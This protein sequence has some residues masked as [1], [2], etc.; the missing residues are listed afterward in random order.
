[1]LTEQDKEDMLKCMMDTVG[2]KA[3]SEFMWFNRRLPYDDRNVAIDLDGEPRFKEHPVT[4]CDTCDA[5]IRVFIPTVDPEEGPMYILQKYVVHGV[6]REGNL[7]RAKLG[8]C[9]YFHT[10]REN[11]VKRY[12]Y[13]GDRLVWVEIS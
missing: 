7:P 3:V 9:M 13:E 5:K 12:I 2:N 11:E 1:M 8:L 10:P 6:K 4:G